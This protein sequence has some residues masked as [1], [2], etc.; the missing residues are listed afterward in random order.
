MLPFQI[1]LGP[2]FAAAGVALTI[3]ALAIIWGLVPL[4]ARA[5]REETRRLVLAQ[6]ELAC[7]RGLPLPQALTALAGDLER[8][9]DRLRFKRRVFAVLFQPYTFVIWLLRR[10]RLQDREA[11]NDMAAILLEGDVA[12]ALREGGVLP[13]PLPDLLGAAAKRGALVEALRGAREIG[14]TAERFRSTVRGTLAY[15]A[16]VLAAVESVAMFLSSAVN[17]RFDAMTATTG[18]ES[19]AASTLRA[20]EPFLMVFVPL[21]LVLLWQVSGVLAPGAGWFS[22]RLRRLLPVFRRADDLARVALSARTVAAFVRAGVPLAEALRAVAPDDAA[23]EAA[24]RRADE[25]ASVA[26]ALGDAFPA[27]ARPLLEAPPAATAS[28]LEAVSSWATAEHER[29]VT[30]L[31]R[32]ALPI[33]IVSVGLLVATFY[34]PPFLTLD[35]IRTRYLW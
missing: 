35:A 27:P 5:A 30:S 2:E 14:A 19:P 10:Q 17:P 28:A 26:A 4:V 21:L 7:E 1:D 23:F 15:P 29:L 16:I 13:A 31:A 12:R 3:V 24:A 34:W 11:V 33:G 32:L 6:L 25:G 18:V 9:A 22:R 8:R 20:I